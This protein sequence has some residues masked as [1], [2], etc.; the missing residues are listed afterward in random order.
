MPL[1]FPLRLLF[2]PFIA[3]WDTRR[4]KCTSDPACELW[5]EM[6][7]LDTR[8]REREVAANRVAQAAPRPGPARIAPPRQALPQ[9]FNIFVRGR[10]RGGVLG[11]PLVPEPPHPEPPRPEPPRPVAQLPDFNVEGDFDWIDNQSTY[12]RFTMIFT[13]FILITINQGLRASA[14]RS[15]A[16]R[17]QPLPAGIATVN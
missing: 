9:L 15:P 3:L 14:I 11:E 8:E 12:T 1:G 13:I 5:D 7:L 6:M 2:T 4:Q 16:R 10:G 17:S